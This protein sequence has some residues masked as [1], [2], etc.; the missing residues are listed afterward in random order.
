MNPVKVCSEKSIHNRLKK[1]IIDQSIANIFLDLSCNFYCICSISNIWLC[2]H[3]KE[4]HN[5]ILLFARLIE[6]YVN[7]GMQSC[8][9][10]GLFFLK[11][12]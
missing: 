5:F 11:R 6:I 10:L 9:C 4:K 2:Y 8:V 12:F 7:S 3:F 1:S